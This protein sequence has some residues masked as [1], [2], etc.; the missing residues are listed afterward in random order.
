MSK[1]KNKIIIA[2][3]GHSSCGKSTV[4]KQIAEY[5]DIRYIDTGAMYR[6]FTL[7]AIRQGWIEGD[8]IN[9]SAISE[10]ID[11][12]NIELRREE[13]KVINTYLNGENVEEAIRS[14]EVSN[15]VSLISALSIVRKKLVELQQNMGKEGG[16]ILDG[17]DIGTVVFPN[18][19]L[20]IFMTAS[21]EI[22]AKRRYDEMI[23]K[24]ENVTF[25]EVYDN[26]VL[27]DEID[28]N[29]DESPLKMADDAWLL[30]NSNLDREQQFLVI[31]EKLEDEGWI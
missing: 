29:R 21:A 8:K 17:R 12:V 15:K 10:N 31:H 14:L 7:Y 26:V 6:A 27:R 16:V 13:G 28:S 1:D 11:N 19:D 18:A 25:K 5:L 30:D 2:V 22:R 24:G 20:K 4:A 9:E 3:D 23:N